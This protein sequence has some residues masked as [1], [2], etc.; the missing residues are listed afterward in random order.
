[1]LLTQ[2][3]MFAPVDL[4]YRVF[5]KLPKVNFRDRLLI[6]GQVDSEETMSHEEL[7]TAYEKLQSTN[8]EL[9]T[10]NEELQSTIEE[11]ETTNEELQ[12]TNEELE[13]MNEELQMI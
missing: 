10:T 7:E 4:R 2:S 12:S 13:T 8:E 6:V 11:L 1:M 3:N 5:C 9:E